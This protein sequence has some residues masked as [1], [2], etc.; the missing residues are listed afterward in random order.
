MYYLLSVKTNTIHIHHVS[1]I[2]A[3]YYEFMIQTRSNISLY[4]T[5][6]VGAIR[7]TSCKVNASKSP[8]IVKEL[9]FKITYNLTV[10]WTLE[11]PFVINVIENIDA[12][13]ENLI[14]WIQHL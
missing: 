7:V 6:V 11:N 9:L 14:R 4:T 10:V 2:F 13:H 1:R 5:G 12:D 8:R 3:V